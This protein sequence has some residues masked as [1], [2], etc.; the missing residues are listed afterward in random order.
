MK[1]DV[2]TVIEVL[3]G[4]AQGL[5][6]GQIQART[7]VPKTTVKRI[8]DRATEAGIDPARFQELSTEQVK[9]IFLRKRRSAM[10]YAEPDWE[11]VYIKMSARGTT[12]LCVLPGR[13]TAL[14]L[15]TH[16]AL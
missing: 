14:A 8:C 3:S 16:N 1:R 10:H 2:F 13:S 6:L 7:G 15:V 12:L 11:A 5:S 9:E 4:A